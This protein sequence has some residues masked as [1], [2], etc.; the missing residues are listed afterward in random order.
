MKRPVLFLFSLFLSAC[1]VFKEQVTD[2]V[3][4]R[5]LPVKPL[6]ELLKTLRPWGTEELLLIPYSY[7]SG[8]ELVEK[9][10]VITVVFDETL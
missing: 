2:E 5:P 3:A 8:D 1:A 7:H 9:Y 10:G 6:V 4:Q